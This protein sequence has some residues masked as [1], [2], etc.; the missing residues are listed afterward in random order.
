MHEVLQRPEWADCVPGPKL[1]RFQES[2][3]ATAKPLWRDNPETQGFAH[4]PRESNPLNL[5]LHKS[6]P[7]PYP[8][9]LSFNIGPPFSGPLPCFRDEHCAYVICQ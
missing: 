1:A 7:S 4:M 2:T 9:A 5:K 8:T 3:N 6:G